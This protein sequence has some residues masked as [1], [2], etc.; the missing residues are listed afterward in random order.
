MDST[1]ERNAEEIR[2]TTDPRSEG[3]TETNSQ[4]EAPP[5]SRRPSRGFVYEADE[6]E[7]MKPTKPP[8]SCSKFDP[9]QAVR[10]TDHYETQAKLEDWS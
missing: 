10:G 3:E 6:V 5:P 7:T 1:R 8:P 4:V 9:V 2:R